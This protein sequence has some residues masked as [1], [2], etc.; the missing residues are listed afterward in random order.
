MGA[1][2]GHAPARVCCQHAGTDRSWRGGSARE[3]DRD[4]NQDGLTIRAIRGAGEL[5]LF[6]R[7]PYVLNEG[8][9]GDL[10]AGRRRPGWMWVALR[11]DRVLA[12]VA[13]WARARESAPLVL[14]VFDLDDEAPEPARVDV[15][16][17]LLSTALGHVVPAGTPPPEYGRLVPPDWRADPAARRVVQDRMDAAGRTGARFLVERLR[18]QW[19]P[20]TPIPAPSGRLAFGPV[21]DPGEL[22]TLMTAVLAGTLDAHSRADLTRMPPRRVAVEYYQGV[23][24]RYPSP[25]D[26]WRIATL[27]AGGPVGF[28]VPAHNDNHDAIIASLGVLPAHR[29]RGFG[30][31]ILAEATRLLAARGAPRIQAAT[32]PGNTP[33]ARAFGRAGYATHAREITMGWR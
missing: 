10:E 20:G 26:W 1:T 24:A 15:G 8:L 12:R 6:C 23:L 5:A 14:D 4:R 25:R 27:P 13:W 22:L 19:R 18:L 31:E 9:R 16:A 7:L 32:D 3:E 21:R 29:G 17:R 28:V 30:G 33:M 11:G 2:D